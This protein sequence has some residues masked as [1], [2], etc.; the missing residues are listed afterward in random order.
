MS[1]LKVKSNSKK[2]V[3][4][5]SLIFILLTIS[6]FTIF[7]KIKPV[8]AAYGIYY[9]DFTTTTYMDSSNTNVTGWGSGTIELPRK[10]PS[11]IGSYNTPQVAEGVFISGDYAYV[12]G[13]DAGRRVIDVSVPYSPSEVGFYETGYS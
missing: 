10:T 11:Y 13:S 12:A 1:F 9:E 5:L 6:V 2:K 7:L 4:N 3:K 8:N